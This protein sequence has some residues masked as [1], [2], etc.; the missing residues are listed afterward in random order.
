MIEIKVPPNPPGG[1][2]ENYFLASLVWFV[3]NEA[4]LAKPVSRQCVAIRLV[5]AADA[6]VAT[7]VLAL[8]DDDHQLLCQLLETSEQG[9][10]AP[11]LRDGEPLEVPTRLERLYLHTILS[12]K[13]AEAAVVQ[14]AE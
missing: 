8:R 3:D 5:N 7:N 11:L 10:C 14:A 4:R 2:A 9:F 12:A 1:P 6:A 13:P